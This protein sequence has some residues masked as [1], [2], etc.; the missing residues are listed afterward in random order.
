MHSGCI[1]LRHGMDGKLKAGNSNVP[2][3]GGLSKLSAILQCNYPNDGRWL[4]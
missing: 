2:S 1:V 4:D 3:E